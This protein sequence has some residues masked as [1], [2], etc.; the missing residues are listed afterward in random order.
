MLSDMQTDTEIRFLTFG[1]EELGLLGSYHYVSTLTA[2]E[3][4]RSVGMF[5]F[6]MV[7]TKTR[8]A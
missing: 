7:G 4:D 5:N 6:D 3:I 8:A 1:A 2:D